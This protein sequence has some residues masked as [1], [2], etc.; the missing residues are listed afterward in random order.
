MIGELVGEVVAWVVCEVFGEAVGML[1]PKRVSGRAVLASC[2][3]AAGAL[4]ASAAWWSEDAS[5]L[6]STIILLTWIVVP[7]IT[8]LLALQ[9]DA[10]VQER[11]RLRRESGGAGVLR[12]ERLRQ[13]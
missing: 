8:I 3:T 10:G 5:K 4:Y 7:S 2:A 13:R 6:H 11:R 1:I 9:Y 12:N